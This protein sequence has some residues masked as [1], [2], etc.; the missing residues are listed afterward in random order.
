M[1]LNDFLNCLWLANLSICPRISTSSR[2]ARSITIRESKITQIEKKKKKEKERKDF[3]PRGV[4]IED[5]KKK[6]NRS[7]PSPCPPPK[8]KERILRIHFH[9]ILLIDDPDNLAI[10]VARPPGQS[11]VIRARK[12]HGHRL[13]SATSGTRDVSFYDPWYPCTSIMQ[14][15][16][17]VTKR[18]SWL[19]THGG[20]E[21]W[22]R[23]RSFPRGSKSS[24]LAANTCTY[25]HLVYWVNR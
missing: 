1:K 25:I 11:D 15:R 16:M 19:D 22:R 3:P 12:F 9:P 8:K 10:M 20:G 2:S 17:K 13:P 14:I 18:C 7:N 21:K 4:I 24:H 5:A 6:K 23:A